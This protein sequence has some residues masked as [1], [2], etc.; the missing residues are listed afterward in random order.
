MV[1]R[2]CFN[3]YCNHSYIVLVVVNIE[4]S[5]PI[6]GHKQKTTIIFNNLDECNDYLNEILPNLKNYDKYKNEL[7]I[8]LKN[9]VFSLKNKIWLLKKCLAT[10]V[11]LKTNS[12]TKLIINGHFSFKQEDD[13]MEEFNS[14]EEYMESEQPNYDE[15]RD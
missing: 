8:K 12:P 6:M 3:V 7:P 11:S 2:S 10:N 4:I 13:R 14:L 9:P 1:N 15:K 5:Y